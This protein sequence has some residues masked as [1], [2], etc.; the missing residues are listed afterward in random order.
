MLIK[1]DGV[2]ISPETIESNRSLGLIGMQERARQY[3]GK[4]EITGIKNKGTRI[5][6]ILPFKNLQMS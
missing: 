4:V 2:G 6:I 3:C 5:S 1:D